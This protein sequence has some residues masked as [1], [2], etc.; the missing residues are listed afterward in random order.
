V[1]YAGHKFTHFV[2]VDVTGLDVYQVKD[3]PN[4]F[5]IPGSKPLNIA[6]RIVRTG[7]S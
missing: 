7:Q 1:P 3:R 2:E 6:G 5:Y 4:V